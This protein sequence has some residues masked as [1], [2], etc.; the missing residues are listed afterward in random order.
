MTEKKI[1]S[2]ATALTGTNISG[3]SKASAKGICSAAKN[4]MT[5]EEIKTILSEHFKVPTHK[6]EWVSFVREGWHVDPAG[7][8]YVDGRR[9]RSKEVIDIIDSEDKEE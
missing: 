1:E 8:F 9:L 3:I 4:R 5:L 7:C 2:S 6:I